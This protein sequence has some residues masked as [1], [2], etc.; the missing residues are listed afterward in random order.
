MAL[1]KPFRKVHTTD[2]DL[3][4]IQDNLKETFDAIASN[5][6]LGGQLLSQVPLVAG[7]NNVHHGLGRN[8]RTWLWM[9]PTAALTLYET[10]SVDPT[11]LLSI[12][13]SAP[14]S[15]DLFVC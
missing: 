6:L 7:A 15:V 4:R 1:F 10:A 14:G 2:Q 5:P 12:V 8:Y 3:N 11:R 9:R 13:A